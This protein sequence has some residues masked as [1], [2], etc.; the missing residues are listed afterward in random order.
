[1][2]V[3]E[4]FHKICPTAKTDAVLVCGGLSEN[5]Q[6]EQIGRCLLYTSRCV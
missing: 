1:M 2:Q 3:L 6:I 4:H 5:T